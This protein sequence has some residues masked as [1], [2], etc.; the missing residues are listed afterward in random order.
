MIAYFF[1]VVAGE[2][3][4]MA[5]QVAPLPFSITGGIAFNN[6]APGPVQKRGHGKRGDDAKPPSARECKV[7]RK[8]GGLDPGACRGRAG[9]R[10]NCPR[11]A[12][13]Q[14]GGAPKL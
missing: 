10:T 13:W 8:Y 14:A 3:N 9:Q 5:S 2:A 12:E 6:P 1:K 11:F 7:C 4:R